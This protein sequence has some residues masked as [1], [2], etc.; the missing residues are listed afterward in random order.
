[1]GL[2]RHALL[3]LLHR[4]DP[5]TA[6]ALTLACLGPL[7]RAPL[8]LCLVSRV[9]AFHDPRLQFTWRGLTFRNP[10]G[11]AAGADKDAR[12]VRFFSAAGMGFIEVGTVTPLSQ[13]GN[14]RPRM[15]RFP[16]GEAMVNR[17]GFP[18]QGVDRMARR[19]ERLRVRDVPLGVNLGK[20]ATTPLD[21]AAEDYACC[22]ERLY[23]LGDYFVLNVSSPNTEGLTSLQARSALASLVQ[24]LLRKR[25]ELARAGGA[26]PKP[27]LVK[28]SPDLSERELDDAVD[29]SLEH[30]VDGI[31]AVNTSTDPALRPREAMGLAGGLSGRP[32]LQRALHAVSH[33][34]QR[35]PNTFF[36]IGVGGV[37]N[38]D[39]AWA[40]LRAGA[41]AVQ[42]YTALT[43]R[44]PA[45]VGQINRGLV[46]RLEGAGLPNVAQA[47]GRSGP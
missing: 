1:M 3:P 39:D 40:M 27:L 47:V 5:E 14:P 15:F 8:F 42:M 33:V 36:L 18:S 31:V 4:L 13:P 29:V 10:I 17:L 22:L 41:N 32:L 38:A 28:L 26:A 43:Y 30:G 35:T 7:Q 46:A 24:I 25:Q 19:L 23:S 6:H 2:Y 11:L 12:V 34:R 9:Y 16:K 44:G 37:S 45:V 20:N 21:R